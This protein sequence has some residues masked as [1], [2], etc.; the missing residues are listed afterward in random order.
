MSALDIKR[1]LRCRRLACTYPV[2]IR[3]ERRWK[4]IMGL[5]LQDQ[6]WCKPT[7]WKRIQRELPFSTERG[8]RK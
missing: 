3:R 7:T 4:R 2:D 1:E 5:I 6:K 8:P